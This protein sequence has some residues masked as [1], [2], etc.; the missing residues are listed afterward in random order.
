M[1]IWAV[2]ENAAGVQQ[3]P[4]P[5][6]IRDF[7][8]ARKLDMAG[9]WRATAI[10]SD[11]RALDLLAINSVVKIY[12]ETHGNP[13][14]EVAAGIVTTR[15]FTEQ[16]GGHG[17]IVDGPDL[18]D[19]LR[20]KN[21]LVGRNYSQVTLTTAVAGLIALVPGWTA[22]IDSAVASTLV[23]AG[24]DGYTVLKA[25]VELAHRYDCHL[26]QS[27]TPGQRQIEISQ[28]TSATLHSIR[29]APIANGQDFGGTGIVLRMAEDQISTTG[30]N[31]YNVLMPLG[32]GEGEA[33]LTL[34]TSTRTSPY[35][36]QEVTGPDMRTLYYIST[37]TY[38]SGG[39]TNFLTDPEARVKVAQM[40]DIGPLSNSVADVRN[41]ADALYDEAAEKL[42]RA[43]IIQRC[44]DV[45]LTGVAD[46]VK[47][48]DRARVLYHADTPGDNAAPY[49]SVDGTFIV[50]EAQES[51]NVD[52]HV[53]TLK[54]SNVDRHPV[55]AKEIL[56]DAINKLEL[57]SL[58]PN[59]VQGAP[60]AY[61]YDREIAPGLNAEVPIE[62]T[63]ST[64]EINRVRMRLKTSP[65]RTTAVDEVDI[66]AHRHWVATMGSSVGGG[67]TR[68]LAFDVGGGGFSG[69]GSGNGAFNAVIAGPMSGAWYTSATEPDLT[70]DIAFEIH[71][72]TQ[73]PQNITVALNG[74]DITQMLFGAAELEPRTRG[75]TQ[76]TGTLADFSFT[77]AD[78]SNSNAIWNH[79]DGDG[80]LLSGGNADGRIEVSLP[81]NTTAIFDS[82]NWG[83]SGSNH[84][85]QICDDAPTQSGNL[86]AMLTQIPNHSLYL[87]AD[88]TTWE[89]EI[90]DATY[91]FSDCL[92][93]AEMDKPDA[94][95]EGV[96]V[97]GMIADS[98]QETAVTNW[99]T[100]S[101]GSAINMVGDPG[102]L[103]NLIMADGLQREHEIEIEC[104]HGRGRVEV[105][106]E[107]WETT[108]SIFRRS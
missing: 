96:T 105:T 21:T 26:R 40:R 30:D 47:P 19:E 63:D 10:A 27:G 84:R 50:L 62:F 71:D 41:A 59:I 51:V 73:Y 43:A 56:L 74:T 90:A 45:T 87:H 48:G 86:S 79:E 100:F 91:P 104:G 24:F 25:L 81:N 36:I 23:D 70:S 58:R 15:Q 35:A 97:S 1:S 92:R 53:V 5:V 49:L 6:A 7:D 29:N 31:Y 12:R 32:K 83:G 78:G 108:Q 20:R 61:V 82:I 77:A 89:F 33:A 55:G 17:L 37:T 66:P 65:L 2:V 16:A 4:G 98:G 14:Q 95:Q 68:S 18:L 54:I 101:T 76:P 8:V 28:L 52:H 38:P 75:G 13:A 88:G 3:G 99:L 44:Y 107:R 93:W 106:I 85:P 46:V 94:I 102:V 9:T 57:H 11:R 67:S 72:D 69:I 39:H 103:A 60:T 22:T 64:L 80:T 42:M 34:A